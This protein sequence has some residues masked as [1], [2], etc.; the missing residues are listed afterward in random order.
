[1]RR[2]R[3]EG[4]PIGVVKEL[5]ETGAHDLLVVEGRD[6]ARYLLSTARELM[7]E[8]D[9][10]AG[11]IVARILPGMLDDPIRED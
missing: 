3:S 8:V 11:R 4:S 10:A 5:W 2:R 1:M 7:P 6:G 9:V